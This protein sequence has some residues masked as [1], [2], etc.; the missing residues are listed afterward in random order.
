MDILYECAAKFVVLQDFE[1]TFVVSKNRKSLELKLN[2]IESDFFHLAGLQYL[3][4]ISIP[5][6]RKK[7]LQAIIEKKDITD[8]VLQKSRFYIHPL[9]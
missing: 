2:F 3:T 8:I 9:Y 7:I 5:Q 4:D 1:Y 6:N